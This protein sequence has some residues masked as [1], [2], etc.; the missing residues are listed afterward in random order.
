[1]TWKVT[2]LP[3]VTTLSPKSGGKC[4][5][6]LRSPWNGRDHHPLK[7]AQGGTGGLQWKNFSM[8]AI[9]QQVINE[10]MEFIQ[11]ISCKISQIVPPMCSLSP[12]PLYTPPPPPFTIDSPQGLPVDFTVLKVQRNARFL[13]NSWWVYINWLNVNLVLGFLNIV[14]SYDFSLGIVVWKI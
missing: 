2:W 6:R 5:S 7:E 12:L 11:M 4:V 9:Q 10:R 1:M 3:L 14:F 13:R 8:M